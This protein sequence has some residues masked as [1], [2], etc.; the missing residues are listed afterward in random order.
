MLNLSDKNILEKYVTAGHPE[1]FF[2]ALSNYNGSFRDRINLLKARHSNLL[3]DRQDGIISYQTY[4]LERTKLDKSLIELIGSLFSDSSDTQS[5]ILT[6]KRS[7]YFG[8][9]TAFAGALIVVLLGLY[10]SSLQSPIESENIKDSPIVIDNSTDVEG[11]DSNPTI[12][13][14]N[15]DNVGKTPEPNAKKNIS[16]NLTTNSTP[17]VRVNISNIE[18][19]QEAAT[20]NPLSINPTP[21]TTVINHPANISPIS[22]PPKAPTNISS[23]APTALQYNC[24]DNCKEV[25]VEYLGYS[26]KFEIYIKQNKQYKLIDKELTDGGKIS[27]SMDTHDLRLIDSHGREI[28]FNGCKIDEKSNIISF[29]HIHKPEV[30]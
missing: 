22:T 3:S 20:I 19:S 1:K 7:T 23:A 25:T 5:I 16:D 9:R 27:I 2:E 29:S 8:L 13:E 18:T 28:P 24:S 21:T 14:S 12:E 11:E 26:E 30:Q 17:T 15:Q 4:S 6:E 10:W